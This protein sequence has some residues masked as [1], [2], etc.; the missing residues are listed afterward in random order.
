M[1]KFRLLIILLL[2]IG[3]LTSINYGEIRSRHDNGAIWQGDWYIH[4]GDITQEI[5]YPYIYV[6][7]QYS[8]RVHKINAGNHNRSIDYIHRLP[9]DYMESLDFFFITQR[10]GLVA[11][12]NQ[13]F[14]VAEQVGDSLVIAYEGPKKLYDYFPLFISADSLLAT[15]R[16]LVSLKTPS[17]P[18]SLWT[19]PSPIEQVV[20]VEEKL[21]TLDD[22]ELTVFDISDLED[23]QEVESHNVPYS[24]NRLKMQ[25]VGKS[26]AIPRYNGDENGI[27]F[28]FLDDELQIED[29]EFWSYD[30]YI[31]VN[32]PYTPSYLGVME[33][34]QQEMFALFSHEN[35]GDNQ[36]S[37]LLFEPER[38]PDDILVET[39][40]LPVNLDFYVDYIHDFDWGPPCATYDN[41]FFFN[42]VFC[43]E[44]DLISIS[45]DYRTNLTV[46]DHNFFYDPYRN[47]GMFIHTAFY[48]YICTSDNYNLVRDV[49]DDTTGE[50]DW[51]LILTNLFTGGIPDTLGI[52]YDYPHFISNGRACDILDNKI[53]LYAEFDTIDVFNINIDSTIVLAYS[54]ENDGGT[55]DLKLF[56]LN[57]QLFS[58]MSN[59]DFLKLYLIQ[60]HEATLLDTLATHNVKNLR[61]N[62][63]KIY[64]H[65]ADMIASVEVL[66]NSELSVIDTVY[67]PFN[68]NR[69]GF[70]I[71]ADGNW[72]GAGPFLYSIDDDGLSLAHTFEFDSLRFQFT[73]IR[74]ISGDR[75]VIYF[76]DPNG[77]YYLC[78]MDLSEGS[79]TDTLALIMDQKEVCAFAGDTL[80]TMNIYS[81][82]RYFLTGEYDGVESSESPIIP[83]EYCLYPAYPNPFNPTVN[84]TFDI[85]Q[86]SNIKIVVY[87]LLGR[88]VT[89]L[90]DSRKPPGFHTISWNGASASGTPVSSGLYFIRLETNSFSQTRKIVMLK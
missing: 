89:T 40:N 88:Q 26:I 70:A 53:L 30:D 49:D 59:R 31:G 60:D 19:Y 55:G 69:S 12:R 15:G 71:A 41:L 33:I 5:N 81:Q 83:N 1:R 24:R 82:S 6:Y 50:G 46:E 42:T 77:S 28:V 78:V 87:D 23:I 8:L 25:T 64:V 52:L 66:N 27:Y 18:E 35:R 43:H 10:N 32:N 13:R 73:T 3:C 16:Y 44:T 48:E 57:N 9:L 65:Y 7:D 34:G 4:S 20:I 86:P 75:A 37:I 85:P 38:Y 72:L 76:Y 54:F 21:F 11:W 58:I 17:T 14:Y 80:W 51:K 63:N 45:N 74:E 68:L 61:W 29:S 22:N 47:K 67:F 2:L 90:L 62:Q 39:V 79:F 56:R 84:I 36:P